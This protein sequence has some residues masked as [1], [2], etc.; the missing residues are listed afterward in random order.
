MAFAIYDNPITMCRESWRDCELETSMIF[1]MCYLKDTPFKFS[2]PWANGKITGDHEA[3][4]YEQL[5]ESSY[6]FLSGT[7]PPGKFHVLP[8]R[9]RNRYV[10]S[11]PNRTH[12]LSGTSMNENKEHQLMEVF[13][14]FQEVQDF[15]KAESPAQCALLADHS[16]WIGYDLT[17]SVQAHHEGKATWTSK[18]NVWVIE[19]PFTYEQD[20]NKV[21]NLMRLLRQPKFQT[22]LAAFEAQVNVLLQRGD[23]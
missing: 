8:M 22:L 6:V 12:N 21:F 18:S 9:S 13:R 7:Q 10:G 20:F 14:A 11:N 3:I 15:V 4:P 2:G 16:L 19:V 1:T 17:S 23:S 5:T